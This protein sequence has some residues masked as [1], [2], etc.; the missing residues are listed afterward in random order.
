MCSCMCKYI[1]AGIGS[2]A[3]HGGEELLKREEEGRRA[4]GRRGKR[5]EITWAALHPCA[6]TVLGKL[7][8]VMPI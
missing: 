7:G 5:S 3:G 6:R 4:K 1:C 2:D 8:E